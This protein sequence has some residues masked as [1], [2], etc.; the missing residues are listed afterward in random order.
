MM[1]RSRWNMSNTL[2]HAKRA[3]FL[4]HLGKTKT[5]FEFTVQLEELSFTRNEAFI[6]KSNYF[7]FAGDEVQTKKRNE[8]VWTKKN[9]MRRE[10]LQSMH[11]GEKLSFQASLFR[12]KNSPA[13]GA[14]DEPASPHAVRRLGSSENLDC[15]FAEAG[16][17]RPAPFKKKLAKLTVRQITVL[18]ELHS[19]Y[20]CM[21]KVKIGLISLPTR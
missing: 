6:P 11:I 2:H 18:E 8:P 12:P 4:N 3:L 16:G 17:G 1:Q 21:Y 19:H 10:D 15:L 20:E 9:T 13:T 7:I 5:V 14:V